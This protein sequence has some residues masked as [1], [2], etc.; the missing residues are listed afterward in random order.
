MNLIGKKI[1][2]TRKLKGLTQE[3]LAEQ[4]NINLRTIQRIENSESEPR[5]KTLQLICNTLQIDLEELI[6]I[7]PALKENSITTKIINGL[8]LLIL[9]LIL[10][11]IIGFLTID[12]NA[13]TNSVFGGVLLSLF[14]PFFI[15]VF[16][17]EMPGAE[18][19]LKFG[20][21]YISYLLLVTIFHGF[22]TGFSTGLFPCL[23][24]SLSILYFGS[25]FIKIPQQTD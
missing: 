16:T 8:F 4:S 21:G 13:N 12:S 5:G 23:L 3:E 17:R 7:D 19:V 20:F 24:I 11:A 14:I 22:P 2:E 25:E 1:S 6:S 10:V 15:V 9:N 18:R